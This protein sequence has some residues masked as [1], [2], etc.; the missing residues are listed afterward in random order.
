MCQN[1]SSSIL[2]KAVLGQLQYLQG[3]SLELSYCQNVSDCFKLINTVIRELF[4][5]EK[6][7]ILSYQ[8]EG[9]IMRLLPSS[10]KCEEDQIVH[11]I[12]D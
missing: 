12:E 6:S 4:S 1:S 5:Y 3:K 2:E 7:S 8:N 11:Q 10:E 9:K